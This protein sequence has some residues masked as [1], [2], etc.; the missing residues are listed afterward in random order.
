MQELIERIFFLQQVGNTI[1]AEWRLLIRALFAGVD[2]DVRRL[3]PTSVQARYRVGRRDALLAEV[4][5]R[6]KDALPRWRRQ[7]KGDL[8]K[9]GRQQAVM[10]R[11]SLIA[12]LGTVIDDELA[13]EVPITEQ[14]M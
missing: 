1:I 5:G 12:T 8:A 13:V 11:R 4:T 6:V 7:V 10:V 3:D 9:L 2:R 14:R